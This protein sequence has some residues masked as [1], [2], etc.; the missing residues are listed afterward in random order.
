MRLLP[1]SFGVPVWNG[2]GPAAPHCQ[3]RKKIVMHSLLLLRLRTSRATKEAINRR[4]FG[5]PFEM[6]P[7]GVREL[8]LNACDPAQLVAALSFIGFV[9]PT[10]G[11]G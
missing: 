6:L 1:V 8:G 10:C 9:F 4:P 3:Q 11:N 5:E 7:S 2:C